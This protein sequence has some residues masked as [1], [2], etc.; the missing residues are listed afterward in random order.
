MNGCMSCH[1]HSAL[2]ARP[3][4]LALGD[5]LVHIHPLILVDENQTKEE[6]P[7][8]IN[9]CARSI[10]FNRDKILES[11]ECRGK[12]ERSA[13][14]KFSNSAIV[15]LMLLIA[16]WRTT[17]VMSHAK[18]TKPAEPELDYGPSSGRR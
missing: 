3:L 9:G 4:S 16:A 6:V 17:P 11:V 14:A 2:C 1:G 13:M 12:L 5:V 18:P 15:L 7:S 8:Y 10:M